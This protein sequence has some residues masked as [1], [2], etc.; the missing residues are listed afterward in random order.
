[1]VNRLDRVLR[2]AGKHYLTW[3]GL[4]LMT[5]PSMVG[6][7]LFTELS[8][9]WSTS[10]VIGV[11]AAGV[12][13]HL[14]IGIVL[15]VDRFVIFPRVH[16]SPRFAWWV[17]GS[18]VVAGA[19]RG[20]AIG[21]VERATGV[22]ELALSLRLPTSIALVAF[23][24]PLA[25]YSLQLWADYG[26][27]RQEVLLSLL[28]ADA[29]TTPRDT[30][31]AGFPGGGIDDASP[32]IEFAR[33]HTLANLAAIRR[34][35]GSGEL[36]R[37][38]AEGIL[39]STDSAWRDTSHDVW[40][41]GLPQIPRITPT[42]LLRTWSA[43][44]PFSVVVLAVGPLYGFARAL[45]T[46][47]AAERGLVFLLWLV[48]AVAMGAVAN[49]LAAKMRAFGPA[50]LVGALLGIQALPVV[51]GYL[52]VG[53]STLLL[54]LWFVA[55]VS[56]TFALVFGFPPALER[57]GQRVIDQLEKWVDQATLE[58]VRAQGEHF[59][60][61]QRLAHYLHSEMRGHFLQLSMSLRRAIE[62]EDTQ[63]ALRVLDDLQ[64]L[65]K[66][67]SPH[68]P[69]APPQEN[70]AQFLGNWARM[71][72][73][74]HNLDTV[75]LPPLVAIATEA[76]VMEAVNDAV[77]HSQATTVDVSLSKDTDEYHLV[78]TSNGQLS[79]SVFSP[80]LGTR[81]L[82]TYAPGRWSRE[83]VS[84]GGHCLRVGLSAA[85]HFE[86]A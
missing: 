47:P 79:Q 43:S 33:A 67:I 71:I 46:I 19:L 14:A 32:G 48:G 28:V 13:G 64:T 44:K 52:I 17:G 27:K 80:G 57:Q 42:E 72:D 69:H 29:N 10:S 20:V 55:F 58:A 60:A 22:G 84:G 35:I 23:S 3:F 75:N 1:M 45:E 16:T 68:A 51:L 62:R 26:H 8:G 21:V 66:E 61:S 34:A 6:G 12:A 73:L 65:V 50:V 49:T 5:A 85:T 56:S 83:A 31:T 11:L 40:E 74:T 37:A 2:L 76:I 24:F 63:D 30:V 4:W 36:R 15:L 59:I 54:Q 41:R 25:A 18:L 38:P 53:D 82:N 86:S 39:D 7:L 77:R 70:L 9:S 81:I 78:I